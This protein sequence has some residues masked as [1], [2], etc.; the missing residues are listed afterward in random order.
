M[1][2][3]ASRKAVKEM[4]YLNISSPQKMKGKWVSFKNFAQLAE[5]S[6]GTVTYIKKNKKFEDGLRNNLINLSHPLV[7]SYLRKKRIDLSAKTIEFEENNPEKINKE[8]ESNP[9]KI[10]EEIEALFDT[11]PD[12][13]R[14]ECSLDELKRMTLYEIVKKFGNIIYFKDYVL[15]Q[16]ALQVFETK[17]LKLRK[18]RGEVIDKKFVK[19]NILGLIEVLYKKLLSPELPQIFTE[20][21]R[22]YFETEKEP[23]RKIYEEYLRIMGQVL[24]HSKEEIIKTL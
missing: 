18:E 17:D 8:I 6:L 14:T 24:D 4:D 13:F 10:G 2:L 9:K 23:G 5:I 12:I 19:T 20:K 1:Y 11:L 7:V 21:T 15:A 22:R 16:T 3:T